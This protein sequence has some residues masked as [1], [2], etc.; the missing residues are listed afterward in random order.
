ML[1]AGHGRPVSAGENPAQA[2]LNQQYQHEELA[3]IRR[4]KRFF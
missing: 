3:L 2:Q 4:Q 1:A